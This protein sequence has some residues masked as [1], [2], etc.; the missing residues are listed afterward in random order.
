MPRVDGYAQNS[1]NSIPGFMPG[2]HR[3]VISR[4]N[5]VRKNREI[6][7]KFYSTARQT[8]AYRKG[9]LLGEE[10]G[11]YMDQAIR[12]S[13]R[14]THSEVDSRPKYLHEPG[15]DAVLRS[16][17]VKDVVMDYNKDNK[18]D[19]TQTRTL[20]GPVDVSNVFSKYGGQVRS[21]V[22]LRMRNRRNAD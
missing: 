9:C 21:T 12:S 19:L 13:I 3:Q 2:V 1:G 18:V 8:G 11:P 15:Y 5:S 20:S 4:V 10:W 14:M 7:T 6:D 16:K 17:T 22:N